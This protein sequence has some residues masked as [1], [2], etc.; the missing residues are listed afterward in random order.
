MDVAAVVLELKQRIVG[1]FVG[2][3]Y[4]I[5]GDSVWITVQS[6]AEGRLDLLLEAGRRIHITR[7]ERTAG[8]TPPQF[9]TMLRSHLSGGRI[10]DVEQ[11]DFDRVVQI[12]VERSTGLRKLV[13]ELFPKGNVVLLDESMR[14]LLPLRPMAFRGRKLLAGEPYVYHAGLQDPRTVS[15]EYLQNLLE[16]SDTD[17]VRTLVRGLNMSGVYGE[18]VCAAAGLDKSRPAS[19]LG[20]EEI[21]RVHSALGSVFALQEIRPQIVL[22]GGSPVDV[23]PAPLR[24]YGSSEFRDFEM[25]SEALDAFFVSAPQAPKPSAV[26]RRLELQRRAVQEQAALEREMNAAGE[27]IYEHY[28]EIDAVLKAISSAKA[29][30]FSYREIWER[31]SDSGLPQARAL[32]SLDYRGEMHLV[33]DGREL[34]LNAELTVPQ[35]AERYYERAKEA[36]KKLAGAEVALKETEELKSGPAEPK[37]PR[38]GTVRR[39]K[40]KWYERFRWFISSDGLL[41][42]GGRD[43]DTNEEIYAKYLERRDLA[44]HTDAPG[45]PLTVIKTEGQEV[46][47]S[48]IQ[49]AAQ[50]AVS[51]SSIWKSGLAA[52]DCY[53]VKGDQVTKTP[54]HGEFLRK[55]AFVI[56]GERRYLRDTAV[57]VAVGIAGDILIGGPVSAVRTKADPVVEVEPGEYNADDLAKRIYRRFSELFEDRRVLKAMAAPDRIA[58]FLPPGGSRERA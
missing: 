55:G 10:T 53:L 43:A 32:R 48:T 27:A 26:D 47:E 16:T 51:Y 17:L 4:Q 18:E 40:P 42:I 34:E 30:G 5:T 12:T 39:R 6:P 13:I 44:L 25:F 54:E 3:A 31:I 36:A 58:A 22:Q 49:E 38:S 21:E 19:G 23:V 2:K 15:I 57:G 50:F 37:K 1:G 28:G 33:V 24:V 8:K 41:V 56:R 29:K 45:A 7:G 46:P 20:T 52:G 9:P 11:Y 14:I 35:N